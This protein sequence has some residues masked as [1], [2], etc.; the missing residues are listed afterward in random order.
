MLDGVANEGVPEPDHQHQEGDTDQPAQAPFPDQQQSRQDQDGD[1]ESIAAEERHDAIQKRMAQPLV[2][3][4]KKIGVKIL[5][6][7]HRG[8]NLAMSWR[9]KMK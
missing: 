1:E 7:L 5:Q 9:L 3:K 4:P 2:D 6:P 8:K